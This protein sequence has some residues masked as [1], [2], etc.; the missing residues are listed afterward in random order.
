[1]MKRAKVWIALLLVLALLLLV[2]AIFM[3]RHIVAGVDKSGWTVIAGAECY[4]DKNGKPLVGWQMIDEKQYYLIP[5]AGIKATAWKTIGNDRYYFGEDGV[6]QTGWQVIGGAKYYFGTDGKMAQGFCTVDDKGYYFTQAG[7]ATGWL[8]VEG[9]PCYYA[10][11]GEAVPGWQELEG[12]KYYFGET[13]AALVGW[14]TLEENLFYFTEEG[15]I[16][17]GWQILEEKEYYFTEEGYALTGWADVDGA[18]CRFGD[19]GAVLAGW[20]EDDNGKYYFEEK[21]RPLV[22]WHMLDEK[23]YYFAEDGLMATDWQELGEDKYFFGEDGEMA[24]G[25]VNINGER[26]FFTSKG[27]Y[28]VLVNHDIPVP[29]DYPE[30]MV[31]TGS[32]LIHGSAKDALETMMREC[33]QAGYTCMIN[34]AYR[35]KATQTTV[36]NRTVNGYMAKGM[37]YEQ[38]CVEAAKDTM[39][40]GHSEHQLGLA[41][42]LDG[43]KLA[44]DWLAANCWEYG[45]ILRYPADS[46]EITGVIHEPWHFRY[47]GT[48]LSLELKELGVCLEEYMQMITK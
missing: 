39:E 44:Y 31:A 33:K 30:D 29:E 27:K 12:E 14:H 38:A 18:A 9:L 46:T 47:V 15:K 26:C 5:D 41:V 35:S 34:N 42:D 11:T 3:I 8:N 25:E 32:F 13:G 43:T 28:I 22:G 24:V 23:Q 6:M 17:T 48:E 21:G 36:W 1:M 7:M 20:F 2:G 37:S 19:D 10:E 4:L 16:L 45:F 40:P